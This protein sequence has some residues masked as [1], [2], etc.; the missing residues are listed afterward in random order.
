MCEKGLSWVT[1]T[2]LYIF[3]SHDPKSQASFTHHLA[4]VVVNGECI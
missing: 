4:S 1:S 2:V 3:S